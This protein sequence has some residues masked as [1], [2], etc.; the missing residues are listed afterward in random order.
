M[1]KNKK[2]K[3]KLFISLTVSSFILTL[4]FMCSF[5]RTRV[6]KKNV[7]RWLFIMFELCFTLVFNNPLSASF[8]HTNIVKSR[9]EEYLENKYGQDF[10]IVDYGTYANCAYAY[11]IEPMWVEF[12]DGTV[13]C[14]DYSGQ[15][16]DNRQADEINRAIYDEVLKPMFKS[17]GDCMI[18]FYDNV[19]VCIPAAECEKIM[20][21]NRL[22]S[23]P[24]NDPKHSMSLYHGY[25]DG[26]VNA[27][28]KNEM[29]FFDS[30]RVFLI[31]DEDDDWNAAFDIFKDTVVSYFGGQYIYIS[32]LTEKAYD[33]GVRE[34]YEDGCFAEMHIISHVKET[35]LRI[36]QYIEVI[37]GLYV[38]DNSY[39]EFV[40]EDGDIRLEEVDVSVDEL[41]NQLSS[42]YDLNITSPIYR[43]VLSDRVKAIVCS[44]SIDVYIKNAPD[45]C[46]YSDVLYT[47][48][49]G[50]TSVQRLYSMDGRW[51]S[52]SFYDDAYYWFG[53]MNNI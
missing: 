33:E 46:A 47:Y 21:S 19:S 12:N 4:F 34:Y 36:H 1:M 15:M 35:T 23:L 20:L 31:C 32:A 48:R 17:M 37:D 29:A 9:T 38:M 51:S 2:T 7:S 49:G 41:Y 44:G 43:L 25:Y 22:S 3:E 50:K 11:E 5:C 52:V 28:L 16:Y 13:V 27:F 6:I 45:K 14:Y 26:N 8:L 24:G 18:E 42:E 10:S 30:E 39:T 53:S 40:F